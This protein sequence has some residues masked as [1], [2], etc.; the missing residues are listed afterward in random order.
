MTLLIDIP[1]VVYKNFHIEDKVNAG[2]LDIYWSI[3][4]TSEED[5]LHNCVLAGSK[6]LEED[7]ICIIKE[8]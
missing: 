1:D 7:D 8:R 5:K 2:I 6:K 3:C 4:D